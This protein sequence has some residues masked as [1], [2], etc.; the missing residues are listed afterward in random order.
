M[1]RL[2]QLNKMLKD[3]EIT[4]EQY[5]TEKAAYGESLANYLNLYL[6]GRITLDDLTSALNE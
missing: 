3:G 5:Q 4:K 2:D 1:N 6:D